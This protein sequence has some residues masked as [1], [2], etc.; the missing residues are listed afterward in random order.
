MPPP[1]CLWCFLSSP[2]N[3][4]SAPSSPVLSFG[5]ICSYFHSGLLF[6]SYFCLILAVHTLQRP[7]LIGKAASHLLPTLLSCKYHSF[8]WR[9][10]TPI[11]SSKPCPH[12]LTYH[13]SAQQAGVSH[14][15][16]RRGGELAEAAAHG[17]GWAGSQAWGARDA[18]A[19]SLAKQPLDQTHLWQAEE[20]A[21]NSDVWRQMEYF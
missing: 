12:L 15:E 17:L 4:Q 8:L 21:G 3:R 5:S 11:S 18:R 10:L 19:P 9:F 14:G 13:Y 7:C 16:A 20:T 2:D 6:V 1:L